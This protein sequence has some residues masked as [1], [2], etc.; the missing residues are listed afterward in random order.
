MLN[1][2]RY[3][4]E[5]DDVCRPPTFPRCMDGIPSPSP[6]ATVSQPLYVPAQATPVVEDPSLRVDDPVLDRQADRPGQLDPMECRLVPLKF[7]RE[8][9]LRLSTAFP[10]SP[11]IDLTFRSPVR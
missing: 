1:D 10:R 5:V 6:D 11:S 3:V 9:S 7:H 8:L 4:A 2:V